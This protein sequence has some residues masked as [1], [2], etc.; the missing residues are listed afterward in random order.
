M[1]IAAAFL[2]IFIQ[3]S[4][5]INPLVFKG[6]KIFDSVTGNQWWAIGLDYQPNTDPIAN[7]ATLQRDI[8]YFKDLGINCIRVYQTDITLDH[9]VGMA[10]LES[11]G[12]YVMLDV[13]TPSVT[14]NRA[15]PVWDTT[16]YE[17][18]KKKIDAFQGYKNLMAFIAGNEVTNDPTTTAASAFVKA[19]IRDVKAHVRE[20]NYTVPVGY[21]T[22]D[23]GIIREYLQNY[24]DCNSKDEQ[25][26]F[27]GINIYRWC[28]DSN[29][30]L[31]G[32]DQLV[33]DFKN[34]DVPVILTEYGCNDPTSKA[35]IFTEVAEIYGPRMTDTISG[36]LV[37]EYHEEVNR[38]GLVN[39]I[40]DSSVEVRDDYFNFRSQI[41]MIKPTGTTLAAYNATG[42]ALKM[43]NCPG[44]VDGKWEAAAV[45]LPPTPD[46]KICAC[47]L[48]QLSCAMKKTD[49]RT[50]TDQDGIT[51]GQQV[52]NMCTEDPTHCADIEAVP[53]TA[54][55]GRYS[56]CNAIIRASIVFN[57][58]YEATGECTAGG[59]ATTKAP[60]NVGVNCDGQV[61][62]QTKPTKVFPTSV[63]LPPVTTKTVP[64]TKAA[65]DTPTTGTIN[66]VKTQQTQQQTNN[67]TSASSTSPS[68]TVRS[69]SSLR[70]GNTQTGAQT[71]SGPLGNSS[72]ALRSTLCVLLACLLA[73][74]L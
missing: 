64:Q 28:Y 42:S 22:A 53:K 4:I 19:S 17:E 58:Y 66:T 41:Q 56:M 44:I 31:S 49:I 18:F 8:P 61:Q 50:I 7:V 15:Y 16:L 34:W 67:S 27:F 70:D 62:E 65:S 47:V 9:D 52:G 23:D 14:V 68:S 5:G 60:Q 39:V 54:L 71:Q 55:Y 10:L 57:S 30:Q 6:N 32:Y 33:N 29:F 3:I 59:L 35:R 12:I 40:S 26:D 46:L 45:P 36:G 2:L 37:Y 1:K 63:D 48:S 24:F 25:A 13:T 38:Y 21:A 74:L 51:I 72:V 43:Q 73:S 69:S 20:M 11:E